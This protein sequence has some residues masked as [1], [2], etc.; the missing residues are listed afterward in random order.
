MDKSERCARAVHNYCTVV[1]ADSSE[2][3][4]SLRH[5]RYKPLVTSV[6]GGEHSIDCQSDSRL[7]FLN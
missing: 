7:H 6:F 4:D 1:D 3:C 5:I 2:L